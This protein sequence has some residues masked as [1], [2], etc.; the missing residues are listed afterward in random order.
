MVFGAETEIFRIKIP[1]CSQQS[2]SNLVTKLGSGK[3][4]F[5]YRHEQDIAQ[6]GLFKEPFLTAL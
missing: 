3:Y 2:A 5:E 4:G 1:N 6:T